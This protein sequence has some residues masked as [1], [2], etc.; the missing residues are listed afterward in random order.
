MTSILF[1]GDTHFGENY[2]EGYSENILVSEG[3]QYT[4]QNFSPFLHD[5][6]SVFANLETP[7]TDLEESPF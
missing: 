6:E 7:V 4:I 2:Q 5:A 1:V 3:Y